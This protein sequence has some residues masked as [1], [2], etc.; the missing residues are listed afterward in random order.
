[1]GGKKRTPSKPMSVKPRGTLIQNGTQ[2]G[3][4]ARTTWIS[5]THK[6]PNG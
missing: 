4:E 5:G 2:G 1:M 3:K 6:A